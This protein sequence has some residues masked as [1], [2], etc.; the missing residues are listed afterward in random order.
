MHHK[1]L[2]LNRTHLQSTGILLLVEVGFIVLN[3]VLAEFGGLN[4]NWVLLVDIALGIGVNM[5]LNHMIA[6]FG[7]ELGEHEVMQKP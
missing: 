5:T 4:I 3:F 6:R 7:R 2:K 1:L